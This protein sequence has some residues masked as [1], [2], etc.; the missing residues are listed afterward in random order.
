MKYLRICTL[1]CAVAFL[2]ACSDSVED[3][4]DLSPSAHAVVNGT[5]VTGRDYLST[6]ALIYGG[7][8]F[9]SGTLIDPEW[10]LTAAHC[11]SN[12][13]N[14]TSIDN[15]ARRPRVTVGIGQSQR[16]ILGSYAIQEFIPHPDYVCESQGGRVVKLSNDIALLHL[17]DSV[18]LSTAVPT[19]PLPPSAAITLDEVGDAS[20]VTVTSVGFGLTDPSNSYSTGTK[21]KTS[22]PVAWICPRSGTQS[23]KCTSD[24]SNY[25]KGFMYFQDESCIGSGDSGGSAFVTRNGREY[26][27]GVTSFVVSQK[28]NVS[29]ATIVSEHY[30]SFIAKHVPVA[31]YPAENCSG[32]TDG[33]GDGRTGCADPWCYTTVQACIPEDCGNGIDDDGNGKTDCKDSQCA[34][35]PECAENCYNDEDDNGDD[36]VD[37]ADPTC[38]NAVRCRQENC[39]NKNDDNENGLTDCD[40]PQC[41]GNAACSKEICDDKNDNDGNHLTDCRDPACFD[42]AVCQI[43]DCTN[44]QDDNANGKID[45]ADPQCTASPACAPEVCDDGVDNNTD[46]LVDCDDPECFDAC[47]IHRDDDCAAMPLRPTAPQGDFWAILLV[48]VA[49]LGNLRTSSK[50]N[51]H[52]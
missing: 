17:K 31:K 43:E 5:P 24:T 4:R 38:A 40:D 26:L 21:N 2:G 35:A 49:L 15:E 28:D 10:V 46:G 29:G 30:D 22:Y 27:A 37:C 42:A 36:L 45:C 12:C 16:D 11:I 33:N 48:V 32:T 19:F 52:A 13:Q 39:T 1:L 23:E 20:K 9:C 6:V 3:S 47:G 25:A 14:D 51:K 44:G 7:Q 41:A 34:G 50:G 18:P 8:A